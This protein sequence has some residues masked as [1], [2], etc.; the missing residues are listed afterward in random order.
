MHKSK[1]VLLPLLFSLFF[2]PYIESSHPKFAPPL[3]IAKSPY[4]S[5]EIW[6][7]VQP[8]LILE[9]HP[10]KTKLDQLFR[11]KRITMSSSTL[12]SAGFVHVRPR[13]YSRCVVTT[14]PLL[15]GYIIKLFLDTQ[16][17]QCDWQKF[18]SRAQGAQSV[19]EA[20]NRL[21]YGSMFKVPKK[22]IYPLPADPAPHP[23][24]HRKNFI[25][26]EEDMKIVSD[27]E[28]RLRWMNDHYMTKERLT[29]YYTLIKEQGL[30]DCIHC[31]NVPFCK[32]GKMA[33]VDTEFHH[34]PYVDARN[35][36]KYLTPNGKQ[37]WAEIIAK[38]EGK[39]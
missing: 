1:F 28:N 2:S 33:F 4:I 19:Q 23:A 15:K 32:D 36:A 26:V 8:Y 10:I 24:L 30:T 11:A 39:K 17:S 3:K 18:I 27:K 35:V 29:A 12:A 22:W 13:K 20:I 38:D 31:N 9:K 6:Q 34:E 21:G 25:L 5:A 37:I 7:K 16:A 14:H